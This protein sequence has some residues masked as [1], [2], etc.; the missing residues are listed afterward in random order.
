MTA[1][2]ELLPYAFPLFSQR[3]NRSGNQP[4][5]AQGRSCA[6]LYICQRRSNLKSKTEQK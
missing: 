1:E 5:G 6:R 3:S 4:L 2:A